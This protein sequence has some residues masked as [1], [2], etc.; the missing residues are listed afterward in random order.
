MLTKNRILIIGIILLS[1]IIGL[2]YFLGVNDFNRSSKIIAASIIS[3]GG[4]IL[5]LANEKKKKKDMADNIPIDDELTIKS[6]VYAGSKAFQI[7]MFLWLAIFIFHESFIEPEMMLGS[8][9]LG[10]ALIYGGCFWY[11]KSTQNFDNSNF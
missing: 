2:F 1:S 5:Y 4:L 6:K 7:S 3:L 8:G 9:I 11:F 10:S